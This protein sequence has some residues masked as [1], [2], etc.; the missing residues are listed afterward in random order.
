MGWRTRIERLGR[1]CYPVRKLAVCIG[2]TSKPLL[3][4]ASMGCCCAKPTRLDV[5]S[6]GPNFV[7][8]FFCQLRCNIRGDRPHKYAEL[9]I[10]GILGSCTSDFTISPKFASASLRKLGVPIALLPR[11]LGALL[12]QCS[13]PRRARRG[14]PTQTECCGTRRSDSLR[15]PAPTRARRRSSYRLSPA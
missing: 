3:L 12:A 5:T 8:L 15:L 2:S 10:V 14:P 1:R 7:E 13:P 6:C 4:M 9:R 11:P